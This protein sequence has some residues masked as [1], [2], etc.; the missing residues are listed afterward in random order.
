MTAWR[1]AKA[2]VPGTSHLR[3]GVPCQDH[4]EVAPVPALGAAHALIAVASDGAG[5]A[6]C[7]DEGARAS[8]AAFLEFSRLALGWVCRAEYLTDGFGQEAL[9]DLQ[10]NIVALAKGLNEPASAFAC[11]LLGAIVTQDSAIFVQLGD[12]AIVFR[13][14]QDGPWRLAVQ[15]QRGEFVNETVFVTRY[16]AARYVQLV[17]VNEPIYEFALMTDGVELLAIKQP[18]AQPHAAFFEHVI[19]GLRKS[20]EPGEACT[21]GR[22]IQ[23]FLESDAVNQRTDDDKT[24]I[25]ATRVSPEP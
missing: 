20:S 9:A 11:T 5:S 23:A 18:G 25:L 13:V 6:A 14:A 4:G 19:A 21:H 10:V 1:Y 12:G 15:M 3:V 24:L 2:S 17:R 7:A 8:C 22:W 16:D